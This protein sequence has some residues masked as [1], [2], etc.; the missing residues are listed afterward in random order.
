MQ[1]FFSILADAVARVRG[2]RRQVHRRRDHG[3]LRRPGR[4]R[5]PRAARLLR[6]AAD[7]R[8]RRRVRGRAAPRPRGS[9]S[10]PGSG[11]TPA[12]S[13]PA[14]SAPATTAT[15]RRSATPSGSRS[16]WRRWP[17]R[18][19]AY[20]TEHTA[21]LAERLPRPRGP[22]RVRDQ[23]RQPA[24]PR[25]RAGRGRRRPLAPRPLPR[26][27]L[28]AL[29]RPR[30]RRWRTLEEALAQ[31]EARRRRRGRDRRRTGRRQ[32][33]ALPRVRRALPRATGIEVF[34][35]RRRRTA[36]SI[37]F[38]PVLQMLRSFFG[39]GDSD[40]DQL[41]AREDRRPGAAA[42]PRASPTSCRCSS[43]SSASPTPSARCRS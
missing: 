9:T 32:E 3:G 21:A 41:V 28:L 16:G 24:G 17:S 8:R 36:R 22:R 40:P 1:R 2:H 35:A 7:A 31:A 20:L 27:R 23:G 10:R 38:M 6:G 30:R 43:T 13:S 11:S 14:R 29:R 34:E 42:R 19:R 15:T 26:P 39:I 37:P 25:L 4:P 5:G 18:A 33:P 12:R